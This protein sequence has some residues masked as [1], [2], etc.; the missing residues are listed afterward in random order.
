MAGSNKVLD[1]MQK[2]E[3]W[4]GA[5]EREKKEGC[6]AV[7]SNN[8]LGVRRAKTSRHTRTETCCPSA[9]RLMLYKHAKEKNVL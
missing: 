8:I 5:A 7:T 9:T 1:T 6:A 4:E 2:R 3:K